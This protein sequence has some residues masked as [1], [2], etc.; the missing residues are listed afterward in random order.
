VTALA[1]NPTTERTLF[2]YA[3]LGFALTEVI[4]LFGLMMAFVLLYAV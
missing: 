1:I 3:I 2:A 4:A